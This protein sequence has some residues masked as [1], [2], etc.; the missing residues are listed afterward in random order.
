M[1][2]ISEI[3]AAITQGCRECQDANDTA[4]AGKLRDMN[5]A[6]MKLQQELSDA[7]TAGANPCPNCGGKPHGME[8]P[9][10]SGGFEFEVGCTACSWFRHSD[11]TVRDHG[12]RGGLLPAHTVEAWNS[13]PDFWKTKNS[14]TKEEIAKLPTSK[15]SEPKT[16]SVRDFGAKGVTDDTTA[17]QAAVSEPNSEAH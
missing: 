5:A 10:P 12:A 17:I 11:G 9:R 6:V 4:P 1:K 14:L 15:A 13:G 2:T 3:K 16:T 7:I 8:Q